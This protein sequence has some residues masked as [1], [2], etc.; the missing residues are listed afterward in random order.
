MQWDLIG[1]W[2]AMGPLARGVVVILFIMLGISIVV[3]IDRFL[4]YRLARNHTRAFVQQ[5]ADAMRDGN[6][7]QAISIAERN[8]K[9]PIAQIVAT[10]LT[11]FQSATTA[12]PDQE[13]MEVAQRGLQRTSAIVHAEL[14]RGLSGLATIGS[15]APFVGLFGTVLG[16]MNA[17]RGTMDPAKGLAGVAGG[18]SEALV[19]TALGLSVAVA[20]VWCYNY[21]TSTTE[22][23]GIEMDNS[24]LELMNYL[25]VRVRQRS[26]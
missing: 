24:S 11:E 16:I 12:V 26:K 2:K 15:T 14:K 13:V 1:M 23:F 8:K 6:L 3:M 25:T 22:A 17:F 9:S 7:D 20:S 19:T 21:F 4:R 10:G 18:I 5:V